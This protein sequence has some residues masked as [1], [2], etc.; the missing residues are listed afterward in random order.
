MDVLQIGPDNCAEK[1]EIPDDVVWHFNDFSAKKYQKEKNISKFA[2][3]IITG[4]NNL[5]DQ[6]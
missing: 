1:Y 5:Q 4:E 6:D 3:V 2:V